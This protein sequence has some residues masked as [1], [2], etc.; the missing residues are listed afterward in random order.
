MTERALMN[1]DKLLNK[2]KLTQLNGQIIF[3]E[4]QN[5]VIQ[6]TK[7]LLHVLGHAIT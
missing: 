6:Y 3:R 7:Q 4:Q 2:F 5:L 1:F